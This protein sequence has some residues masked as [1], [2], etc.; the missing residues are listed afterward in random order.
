MTTIL[1]GLPYFD[2]KTAVVVRNRAEAV[3]RQ[4]IVVWVSLT[5][6]F[7]HISCEFLDATFCGD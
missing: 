3:K 6:D 1:R 7:P 4:Q 2:E 5:A